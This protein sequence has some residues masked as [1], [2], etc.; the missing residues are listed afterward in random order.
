MRWILA[1]LISFVSLP[2]FSIETLRSE[3]ETRALSD[4]LMDLAMKE[5]PDTVFAQLKPYWPLDPSEI[6]G[7]AS[8]TKLKW[9]LVETRYGKPL[10]Y[11]LVS[12]ERIGESFV[13][14]IYLQKFENHALRWSFGFYRPLDGWVTNSFRF[15]DQ[16]ELLYVAD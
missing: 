13:R 9:Q 6:D 4:R 7:M 14:Y 10:A 12:V 3:S 2:A 15:D 8:V 16:I 5:P 1:V 11:E